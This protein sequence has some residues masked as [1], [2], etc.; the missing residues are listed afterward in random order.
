MGQDIYLFQNISGTNVVLN[1][2]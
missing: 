2:K 1:T